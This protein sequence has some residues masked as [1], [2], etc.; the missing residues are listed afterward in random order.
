MAI[1]PVFG[2]WKQEDHEFKASLG[3]IETPCL[4]NIQNKI[5]NNIPVYIYW[6]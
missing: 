4:K 3:Y 5:K 1:M 2:R 6:Y